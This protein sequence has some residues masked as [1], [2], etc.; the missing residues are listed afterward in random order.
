M[1]K[2]LLKKDQNE[3]VREKQPIRKMNWKQVMIKNQ[4]NIRKNASETILLSEKA[5]IKEPGSLIIALEFLTVELLIAHT[6]C[7]YSYVHS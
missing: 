3:V 7:T 1:L 2:N 5:E 6:N 4:M